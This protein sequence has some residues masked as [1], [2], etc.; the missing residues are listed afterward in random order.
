MSESSPTISQSL[1]DWL[2]IRKASKSLR[3]YQA[4][5]SAVRAF[6][7]AIGDI[8][9]PTLTE[10]HY[11]Q[12]LTALK[13]YDVRTEVLYATLIYGWFVYLGAKEIKPINLAKLQ[14]ARENEQRKPGKRLRDFDRYALERLKEAAAGW[15]VKPDDLRT[16]RA[17]ALVVLALDSGLRVSE[18][19]NLRIGDL[20]FEQLRG[21]VIGKGNKQ[22][23]FPFTKKSASAIRF[24]VNMRRRLEP[25]RGQ[26]MHA[27][28]VP[29]FVSHSKR[30]HSKLQPMDTDTARL[31]L[32]HMVTLLISS[33]KKPITPHV[34]R[35][36]A[37]NE[38]RKRFKDLE[39]VRILLGHES[40]ETTK[41][42]MHVEEE[43]ALN[44][45][46]REFN[47]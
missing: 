35:H 47:E 23:W 28:R 43:E 24:Y 33:P 7:A 19:C 10:D 14:Y 36:Y 3:T 31:D 17:K 45:Y 1:E 11:S 16:A 44:A 6:L 39:M 9:L 26:G 18:L 2:Q 42:Y 20:D 8:P 38:L 21:K 46:H 15:I 22:R 41:G 4:S 29:V 25:K 13:A 34:L 40:I 27:E 37:G 5:K 12:F 30:G 32:E